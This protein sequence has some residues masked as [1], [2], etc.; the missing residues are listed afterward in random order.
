MLSN[1]YG[2]QSIWLRHIVKSHIWK[3]KANGH[4]SVGV[5]LNNSVSL[6]LPSSHVCRYS[7]HQANLSNFKSSSILWCLKNKVWSPHNDVVAELVAITRP[8]RSPRSPDSL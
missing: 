6:I 3:R 8:M 4:F 5:G 7:F 2:Q 1:P